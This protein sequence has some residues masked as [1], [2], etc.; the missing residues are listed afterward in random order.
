MRPWRYENESVQGKSGSRLRAIL[1][2]AILG[3]SCLPPCLATEGAP[4][5]STLDLYER[6]VNLVERA[7]EAH[8]GNAALDR[9]RR[10]ILEM[11]GTLDRGARHQGLL[12]ESSHPTIYREWLVLDEDANRLGYQQYHE[13]FDGAIEWWRFVYTGSDRMRFTSPIDGFAVDVREPDAGGKRRRLSRIVPIILLNDARSNASTIRFLGSGGDAEGELDMISFSPGP[14][15]TVTLRLDRTTHRLAGIEALVDE[16]LLGDTMVEWRFSGYRQIEGLGPFPS[17]YQIRLGGRLVKD[18]SF[19][20]VEHT[21]N[22]GNHSVFTIP[23]GIDP[24]SPPP[25]VAESATP[26]PSRPPRVLERAPGVWQIAG[27]RSGFNVALI[28]LED[29]LVLYDAPAGWNEIHEIPPSNFVAGAT[30]SSTSE[31]LIRIAHETV[32]GKPI[33]YAI[34]SHFHGDHSGGVRAFIAEGATVVTTEE[35]VDVLRDAAAKRHR[36]GPDR[37]S[38]HSTEPRFLLVEGSRILSDDR[39]SIVIMEVGGNPHAE[40]LLAVWLPAEKIMFVADLF[41]ATRLENYPMPSEQ[42]LQ[43]AFIRWLDSTGLEPEHIFGVHGGVGTPEHLE[44][45]RAISA[46]E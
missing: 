45:L 31:E 44:K 24:P 36:I 16:P 3:L 42:A 46:S 6:G 13:R 10:L 41:H 19:T 12:P 7:F 22:A 14:G 1:L 34:V 15:E 20:R 38:E 32:P 40:G 39:R 2:A 21:A 43:I 26:P 8:G 17:R 37:L 29:S 30:S 27:I 4:P 23:E 33:R 5:A 35:A 25:E 11:E 9:S 28:E 18:V